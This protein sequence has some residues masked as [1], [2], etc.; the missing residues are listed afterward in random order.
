MTTKSRLKRLEKHKQPKDT[1]PAYVIVK[2]GDP[3]P[4]G[5]KCYSPEANPDLWDEPISEVKHEQNRS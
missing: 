3:I 4:E 2:D 5:V 1:G